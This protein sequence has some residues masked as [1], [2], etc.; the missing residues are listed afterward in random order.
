MMVLHN[1]IA[2]GQAK[3]RAFAF[4]AFMLRCKKGIENM[5]KIIRADT[6][7][8][9]GDLY[10][11]TL[12]FRSTD[13]PRRHIEHDHVLRPREAAHGDIRRERRVQQ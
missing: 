5:L 8:C 1:L 7:T 4:I 2:D 9:V 11:N 10:L 13:L 6:T 12:D 3:P